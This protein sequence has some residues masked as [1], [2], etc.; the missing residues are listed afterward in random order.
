VSDNANLGVNI[1]V[2]SD[3]NTRTSI[4]N[5]LNPHDTPGC[6]YVV[7]DGIGTSVVA[8]RNLRTSIA[9]DL[10]IMTISTDIASDNDV[11]ARHTCTSAAKLVDR[12]D[13]DLTL[14]LPHSSRCESGGVVQTHIYN[15]Q[16]QEEKENKRRQKEP[17]NATTRKN[18]RRSKNADAN[19]RHK[20]S[21][22]LFN[23]HQS[24]SV[25]HKSI[26]HYPLQS[27]KYYESSR[28]LLSQYGILLHMKLISYSSSSQSRRDCFCYQV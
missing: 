9:E 3:R 22:A 13:T 2:V 25:Y 28:K 16:Q 17:R 26:I 5:N 15:P 12:I 6:I 1:F 21:S 27:L 4:A 18:T 11:P 19:P 7:T 20:T 23:Q 14:F 24:K 8:D 10:T